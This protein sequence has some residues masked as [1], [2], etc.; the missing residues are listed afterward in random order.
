MDH[1]FFDSLFNG[2]KGWLAAT[3][4]EASTKR[5]QNKYYSLDSLSDFFQVCEDKSR[6]GWNCYFV[7]ATMAK[8]GRTKQD[9]KESNVVWMDYDKGTSLPKF[10]EPLPSHVVES[11]PGKYHVYWQLD[12]SVNRA[13]AAQYGADKSGVDCTQLLRVPGTINYKYDAQTVVSVKSSY[14][15]TYPVGDFKFFLQGSHR[16]LQLLTR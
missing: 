14:P 4:I 12:E 10:E 15:L 11:S 2:S 13:L 5:V 3:F 9:F 7:P 8:Q 16:S 6:Q 1:Q